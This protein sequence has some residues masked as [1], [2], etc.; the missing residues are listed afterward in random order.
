MQPRPLALEFANDRFG[1][2]LRD[3]YKKMIQIRNDHPGLRS[4]NVYPVDW[5][6]DQGNLNAMGYGVQR[7]TGV[8]SITVGATQ[9]Q[10]L[11]N[12]S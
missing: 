10:G 9:A 6:K 8:S 3:L 12:D 4:D 1:R 5:P 2:P 7:D 11:F